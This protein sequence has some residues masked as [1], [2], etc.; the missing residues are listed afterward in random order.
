MSGTS[1]ILKTLYH[2]VST[3]IQE[4]KKQIQELEDLGFIHPITLLWGVPV[5]FVKKKDGSVQLCLETT[6]S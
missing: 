6:E 5:L 3:K 2:M 1:L 4:L